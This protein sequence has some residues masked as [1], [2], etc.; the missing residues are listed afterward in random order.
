MTISS[1]ITSKQYVGNGVATQF[2]FPNKIFAATDLVVTLIDLSGTQY[3]FVNFANATTG[4]SYGVQGVDVDGGCTV[5][6][7]G[8][9]PTN[10]WTIDI[11]TNTP[12]L[13]GAALKNQGSF[14]PILHEEAFDK[15]TRMN[16][17]ILR[18]TY[19][20]GIHGP[21]I[22]STP[23][24]ALPGARAR[25]GYALMF[26]AVTG[27]PALGFLS[28]QNVTQGLIGPIL[29]PQT[30]AESA[31]GVT[32]TNY[33]IPSHLGTGEI[34]PQRYGAKFD[35]VTNDTIAHHNAWAVALQVPGAQIVM[36]S[37]TSMVS[38]LLF[39][40]NSGS[41]PSRA[42]SAMRGQGVMT[43][44]KAIPGT[45]GTLLKA[46]GLTSTVLRDFHLDCNYSAA[47]GLDTSW[48]GTTGPSAQNVYENIASDHYLT[49]GWLA[50]NDNQS[51]FKDI[52]LRGAATS[53]VI[54]RLSGSFTAGE[55]LTGRTS[56]ATA[57]FRYYNPG[58]STVAGDPLTGI[59]VNGETIT[60]GTS[61]AHA[62][63]TTATNGEGLSGFRC[64]G[65]GG[66]IFLDNITVNN[67][68]LSISAQNAQIVAGFFFG[69]RFNESQSAVNYV[70]ICGGTQ[71]YT[72]PVTLTI[73]EDANYATRS[74]AGLRA[75]GAFLLGVTSSSNISLINCGVGGKF[76]FDGCYFSSAGAGTWNLYGSHATN[77]PAPRPSVVS[78][79]GCECE[80]LQFNRVNGFITQRRDCDSTVPGLTG[81]LSDFPDRVVYRGTINYPSGLTANTWA[82]IVPASVLCE[83]G[84]AYRVAVVVNNSGSDQQAIQA[85]VQAITKSGPGV[86][87]S[88]AIVT[89]SAINTNNAPPTLSLR[90]GAATLVGSKYYSGVDFQES[91]ALNN[92]SVIHVN[93]MRLSNPTVNY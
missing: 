27:L 70:S 57:T 16:Q 47:V 42:P 29:N 30:L 33:A 37:G 52:L 55:T 77:K 76:A 92:N 65:S 21:D 49:N 71:I 20:Y 43:T 63:A 74:V 48:P 91:V 61:G 11:R 67:C 18:Q 32:P 8:G 50:L 88:P 38:N 73:F 82:N 69:I 90:Y 24:P 41:G 12:K 78:F 86:A 80:A 84:A 5:H 81:G 58:S 53:F 10:G 68:F 79:D 17:D 13:Q 83:S 85:F 36:P 89:S 60:G 2:A 51:R 87:A 46:N 1:L 3:P 23:W 31:A 34:Y 93:V 26:D 35:G 72:N 39:G 15:L 62:T 22:E 40:S 9:A 59:F 54:S 44:L 6:F 14:L 28:A 25:K 56:G 64:E 66:A 19:T 4:L 45:T 75:I 7:L